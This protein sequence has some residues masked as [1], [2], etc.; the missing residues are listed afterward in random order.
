MILLKNYSAASTGNEKNQQR[1]LHGVHDK[2]RDN[3]KQLK[4]TLESWTTLTQIGPEQTLENVP[5]F[6]E[7]KNEKK[8]FCLFEYLNSG[9]KQLFPLCVV[10]FCGEHS[11]YYEC[12]YIQACGKTGFGM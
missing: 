6:V 8:N 1:P 12:M 7:F 4:R 2:K 5:L 10:H 3:L 11:I 9:Q